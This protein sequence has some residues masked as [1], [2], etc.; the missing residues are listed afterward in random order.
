MKR[1]L[2]ALCLILFVSIVSIIFYLRSRTVITPNK[3]ALVY[4][5]SVDGNFRLI[6][7]GKPFFIKGVSGSGFVKELAE[8]GGNTLRVY[9][10]LNLE[11]IFNEAL[12]YNINV[13]VDIPIPGSQY[14]NFYNSKSEVDSLQRHILS[15]VDKYKH[16]QSLLFWN[17]GNETNY[18]LSRSTRS[19]IRTFNSLVDLIH[20]SDPNH[21]ISTTISGTSR[22]QLIAFTLNSPQLDFYGFNTF[23]SI[24]KVSSTVETIGFFMSLKPYFL[25]EW[26]WNGPWEVQ[27]NSWG[28]LINLPSYEKAK[29]LEE[30]YNQNEE[31]IKSS[32]GSNV[33]YWGEK[34]EGTPTW[35]NILDS[36]G[37]KTESYYSLSEIWTQDD[38]F[39][40]A[41]NSLKSIELFSEDG[42][43]LDSIFVP[44][45]RIKAVVSIESDC[46]SCTVNWELY[47]EDTT[48]APWA[49]LNLKA[50]KPYTFSENQNK[51]IN[52]VTP[53]GEGPYR[54]IA[55]LYDNRGNLSTIDVPLYVLTDAE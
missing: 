31:L 52:F 38:S 48:L 4:V 51:I 43:R 25:S 2:F 19:F 16:H 44:H 10:T 1:F 5:D 55:Y 3:N 18:H 49:K 23:S 33:F 28:A 8:A 54:L 53:L 14:Q 47:K 22:G 26:G 15:L 20:E 17:L 36:V 12:Q 13:I 42:Q 27:T 46:D 40:P 45:T 9:D 11:Q 35:F 32:L 24:D 21:P 34:F 37:N 29:Q 39:K 30:R 6:K 50:L 7:N 41:V